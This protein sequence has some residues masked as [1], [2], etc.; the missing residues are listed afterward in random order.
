MKRARPG[1]IFIAQCQA[2]K[3]TT[4]RAKDQEILVPG[5]I[6]L[7]MELALRNGPLSSSWLDGTLVRQC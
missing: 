7:E 5:P 3:M 4:F 2:G 6:L 1:G